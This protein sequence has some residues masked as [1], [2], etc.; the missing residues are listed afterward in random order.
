MRNP[1]PSIS[2]LASVIV[3]LTFMSGN[4]ADPLMNVKRISRDFI[5]DLYLMI[6]VYSCPSINGAKEQR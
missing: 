1:Y 6:M 3:F 5:L 2:G 4:L